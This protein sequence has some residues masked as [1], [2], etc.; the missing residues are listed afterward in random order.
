[1]G[2]SRVDMSCVSVSVCVYHCQVSDERSL[3]KHVF[4]PFSIVVAQ[5][6][7]LVFKMCSFTV[8]YAIQRNNTR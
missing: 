5:L 6:L 1:M 7:Y 8:V 2:V 3:C 4:V